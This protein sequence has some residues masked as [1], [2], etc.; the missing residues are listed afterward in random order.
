MK[1]YNFNTYNE[2]FTHITTETNNKTFLNYLE[3]NKYISLSTEEF[4]KKVLCLALAL[5]NIGIKKNDKVAIFSS[6]SVFWLIFDFAIHQIAA[7][8]VPIFANISTKNLNFEINDSKVKYLIIDDESR[9]EDINKDINII[10]HGFII[11][12]NN[13]FNLDEILLSNNI[14]C[15][16]NKFKS[17]TSFENDIFSIIYTSGNTGTPKGVVLTHKNIISQ[18]KDINIILPLNQ[19][20]TI[21]S[22]LPLAHIFERT[23]MSFYLSKGV[24]IYFIDDITNVAKLLK[25]VK[26]TMLTAVPRL[27]EKI[28]NKIK[29]NI[30][31]KSFFSKLIA[32]IAFKYASQ[33]NINRNNLIFKIFDKLVYKRFREIFGNKVT[34]LVSGG[35]KLD[36]TIAIFFTNIGIN[37]YQ[38][39]GLTEFSPVISTNYPN[40]N[41]LGSCGKAL[42]N[43]QVKLLNNELLVKGPSLMKEYLNDEK[44][45]KI[46]VDGEGW[47]HTGDL[48]SIDKEGYIYINSRVK[49]LFKTST[50]QYVN[51]IN[52]E[53]DLG[54]NIYLE[55]ALI[56]AENKKYVTALLF[57]NKEIFLNRDKKYKY[58][59][60]K[61]YYN[62]EVVLN[63]V[64]KTIKK[65]NKK[66]NKWEKI[67]KYKIITNDI[68]IETGELTPSMKISRVVIEKKYEDIINSM[69]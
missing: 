53:Q 52:I 15:N 24:S 68:S 61:E 21:L 62:S 44:L 25:I 2:L 58:L 1:S 39:Y 43:V 34:K 35:A 18:L 23:V 36:K 32:S 60:I 6:S 16:I 37:I 46:T 14:S 3:D 48:A 9:L 10:T 59:T 31:N 29:L 30:S 20:E 64:L 13:F 65:V 56:F 12:K 41:K 7:I 63:S 67:I 69:Y 47:L 28:F 57:I 38:G 22:I 50:G 33:E 26:P 5:I 27:L 8:S 54:R 49:E 11:N 4:R 66:L 51:A 17:T 45:T 42:K 40:N 55:F 19:N